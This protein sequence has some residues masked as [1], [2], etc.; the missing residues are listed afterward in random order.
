[1]ELW[2]WLL[3]AGGITGLWLAGS[4]KP[5]GWALGLAMQFLWA[6]FAVATAQYGFLVTAGAYGAVYAR[7]WRRSRRE[8]P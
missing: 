3:A 1:M 2:S 7:N 8:L 4:G 5:I 6:A